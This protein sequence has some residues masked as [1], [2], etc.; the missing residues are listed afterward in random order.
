MGEVHLTDRELDVMSA[1]WAEGSGTV[2]EVREH[3]QD[4]L[5][6]TTVLKMLQILTEKGY[7]RHEDEG[8]R[9]GT[10]RPWRRRRPEEARCGGSCRRFSTGPPNCCS[11]S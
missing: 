11:P 9:T 6:Y 5:A 4:D 3:I 2:A 1:L 10:T 7:V 8:R